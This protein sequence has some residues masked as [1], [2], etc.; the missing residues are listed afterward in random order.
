MG[1]AITITAA[2]K[3]AAAAAFDALLCQDHDDANDVT[4]ATF[5][6]ASGQFVCRC[7]RSP[8]TGAWSLFTMQPMAELDSREGFDPPWPAAE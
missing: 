1:H 2:T 8:V 3:G 5:I 4:D 7:V 6:T